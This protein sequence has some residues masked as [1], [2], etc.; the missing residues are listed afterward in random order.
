MME[1]DREQALTMGISVILLCFAIVWIGIW[2]L[3]LM[4]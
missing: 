1:P 4:R 2:A 3:E